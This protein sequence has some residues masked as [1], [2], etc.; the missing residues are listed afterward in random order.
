MSV[1]TTLNIDDNH[2][3]SISEILETLEASGV[4]VAYHGYDPLKA[5]Q[6]RISESDENLKYSIKAILHNKTTAFN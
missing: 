1:I 2:K 4:I 5:A 6:K 3:D